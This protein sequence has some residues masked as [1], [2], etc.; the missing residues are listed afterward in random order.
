MEG[1]HEKIANA[2]RRGF[3]IG[4]Q[5]ESIFVSTGANGLKLWAPEGERVF[6]KRSGRRLFAVVYGT[7]A[8]DGTRLMRTYDRFNSTNFVAYLEQARKKWGKILLIVDNAAQH[9]SKRV[10]R[11]PGQNPDVMVLYL[12]VARPE[13]SAIEAVWQ[14]AKYRLIT[15]EF[16][17]TLDDLKAA[18]SEYFRTCSITVN[19]CAY[20]MR[21]I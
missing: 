9:K 6:V 21:N 12:P 5:D 13:L 14:K 8:D 2:K 16:Y 15:V 10:R 20:L 19:I 4:V 1:G 7:I 17:K 11:Y 3:C 18:V